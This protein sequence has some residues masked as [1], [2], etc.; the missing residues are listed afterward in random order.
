MVD[1]WIIDSSNTHLQINMRN[2]PAIYYECEQ[3]GLELG[4]VHNHPSETDKYS[5]QDELNEINIL[6][7]LSGC[8]GPDTLLVS[9]LYSNNK[10]QARIRQSRSKDNFIR[11]RH[12]C[13]LSDTL[14]LYGLE[15]LREPPEHLKRQESAFGKP[16]NLQM[17]S[18]RVA[19][20]GLGGT[21]SPIATML[22]RAGIGE[23]ILIDGDELDGTNMNRVRGYTL[24]HIGKNK[25]ISLKSYIDSLNL[26]LTVIAIP[27]YLH[28]S[29]EAL[30]AISTADVLFGCTDDV[31][32]RDILNQALFYYGQVLIDVGLTGFVDK[33]EDGDPI[34]RDHR[35]RVSCIL[36]EAGACL[37]CQGVVTD[38]KIEYEQAISDNPALADL[39]AEILQREHYLTG[40]GVQAPGVGPFTSMTA[41]NGVATL[42]NLLVKFR[43]IPEDLRFD[44]IWIDFIHLNF[45]SNQPKNNGR[46]IYCK[47]HQI[48][49][50]KEKYRLDIPRLGK[51]PEYA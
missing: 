23:L 48:L 2:F 5:T 20:V 1:E 50:K 33:V 6:K 9:M 8:N 7:G 12:I 10:W 40:G 45:H 4:F 16:F 28:E 43:N 3:E 44:N 24:K 32:G 11:V 35:G 46:C 27:E 13:I 41:E 18:L 19:V 26:E 31:K 21:G 42:M 34:L 39:D 47:E 25:A 15:D 49:F 22:A 37:R 17:Q 14:D 51:V 30:D 38:Q 36:P 29:P